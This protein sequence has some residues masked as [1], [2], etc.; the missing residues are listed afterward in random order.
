V[1]GARRSFVEMADRGALA[2]SGPEARP[3]LQGL[4]SND[5]DQVT[6]IQAVYA[7][8]LTPQGKFLFDFIILQLDDELLLETERTRLPQLIQR[9]TMYRLRSKV[10]LAD[11][12]ARFASAAL[13]GAD[14][15]AALDLPERAGAC[16]A[17]GSGVLLI[18]PRLVQLGGRALLAREAFPDGLTQLGFEPASFETYD[19]HRLAL[20]VPDGSR[21]LPIEKATLLL[22]SY[23]LRL[24]RRADQPL[25]LVY[26]REDL[27][28]PRYDLALLA[29]QVLGQVATEVYPG[30]EERGTVGV[31]S[32]TIVSPPV[33]WASLGLAVAVLLGLIVRLIR[34]EDASG[35][36]A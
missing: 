3:F 25:R 29:P 27:G 5:I 1:T 14:V 7:A 22:P 31:S 6:P 30:R 32:A 8:L 34:R 26:G 11:A 23:A 9:L 12:S 36:P 10:D 4:I 18:D 13:L 19:R 35:S 17:L 28:M 16:R 15:A 2:V 21:D 20:G 33:F 24:F